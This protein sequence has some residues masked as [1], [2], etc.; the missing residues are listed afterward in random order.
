MAAHKF[1]R[2]VEVCE[3]G[4]LLKVCGLTEE[5][6]GLLCARILPQKKALVVFPGEKQARRFLEALS[7]FGGE[8]GFLFPQAEAPAF[9]SVYRAPAESAMRVTAL[10]RFSTRKEGFLALGVPALL[11]RTIPQEAL[12]NSYEYLLVGEEIDREAFLR[13]LVALGYEK[14]GLV[15]QIGE[16]AVRGS[17]ID[18][19]PPGEPHPLRLDFFGDELE[20]IKPFDVRSQRSLGLREEA[21]ILPVR[22]AL[23]EYD[24][25]G[26]EERVFARLKRFELSPD[27]ESSYLRTLETKKLLEPEELWLPLAYEKPASVFDYLSGDEV[28]ILFEPERIRDEARIFEEKL[29]LSWRKGRDQRRLLVEPFESFLSPEEAEKSFSRHPK[30]LEVER[31]PLLEE[32]ALSFEVRDHR[33]H[34]ERL[35]ADPRKAIELGLS[36][37]KE[38]L[39]AG[40]R[41]VIVTPQEKAAERLSGLL[42]RELGLGEIPL[43]EA[44]LEELPVR[45]ELSLFRGELAQGFIW[46]ELG[47]FVIPEHELF[48]VR[49]PLARPR[50]DL[51]E[52]F[53]QFEDL[54]PGDLVVHREHGIGRYQGLVSLELAGTK[55]EFLL[56][57]YRD[58]DKL[59]LPVDKLNL[60]H[61]YVGLEGK[62]PSLDR[63]GG[64]SFEARKKK[65]EKAIA[66]VAEELLSLYAARKVSQGFAF[67]PG[68]LLRQLEATFPYEETPEQAAAIEETL[69]DM[70]KPSPMDRLIC[71]DVG[72]GKTEVALRATALAVENQKQ[73]AVLV[74]TTVLAEQ[75]FRTF[76][77]RLAPLGVRV[78]SLS[79]LKGSREQKEILKKLAR[80]EV[81][82]IIGTHRLLSRD[83]TFKDLGL[84]IIDEEH[85]FGVRHKERLKQLKKNVDVLALS[86][87]PIPRTLQLSLLGIRDLSVITT[88]P[89]ERMPVKTFVARFDDQVIKEAIER[90]L[91]RGGQVFFVHNRIKGIYALA[92]WLRRLVPRARIE[93]AHGR[94]PPQQ[95]EE[96]M[97]RFV[98]GEID[99][100]VCTTIIESGLDIPSA[101]TIIINRADRMGLAEIYQLRGRVGRSNVQAYAYLLVPS[102][103]A[104]SEEAEKRLRALMQFSEL[105]SGFKL[106]MSDLQ[107]RGAGNLLGTFQSGHVAAVGYDL[108][109]EILKRTIDE[110]RG[111]PPS[112]EIEPDVNLKLPAYFPAGYVPDVEQRLNLYR[113]LALAKD[114]SQIDELRDEIEDRFGPLPKE[115]ENLITL[116]RLKVFLRALKVRKLDRRGNE[117]IFSFEPE[118]TLPSKALRKAAK[119]LGLNLRLTRDNRAILG[120]SQGEVLEGLEAF[121]KETL[122][123]AKEGKE[124][125]TQ[126]EDSIS[127]AEER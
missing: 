23:L 89:R 8:P 70:Q 51:K 106:A 17:V 46:P 77:E 76:S 15:Q 101:N 111:R 88:P 118:A 54:K 29:L 103:S 95:L 126:G 48:G 9:A 68:P 104:L 121:L 56:I 115:A 122:S 18:L 34:R 85:R 107:I 25:E 73:V 112:E 92:D 74:P 80:G 52:T 120:L 94:T 79:R 86:A 41:P 81:D 124:T 59:Y 125:Y 108:Y 58:G 33:G 26:L 113:K 3:K 35:K 67:E 36:Y 14:T 123:L 28:L 55:G 31:L 45:A 12:K 50:R 102:L 116:S 109:L 64:K 63:L 49:R 100:L 38:A 97:I 47:L 1:E 114:L 87:T 127:L 37:L 7:F 84:L 90:E 82:V 119:A 105:G 44:P 72:Y 93:V 11:R 19:F 83:V 5:A 4:G 62:E 39:A 30:R 2:L 53:L 21:V 6:L 57:E 69:A 10:Y 110:M 42:A 66:E 43:E 117:V 75:H 13:R 24:P 20:S 65:V 22:E 32:G 99:V 16:F 78:A 98:R 71:G 61:K 91:A 27:K 40:E 96:I 60:L